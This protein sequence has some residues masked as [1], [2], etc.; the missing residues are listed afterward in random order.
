MQN[1]KQID[2]PF[3]AEEH[4]DEAKKIFGTDRVPQVGTVLDAEL[5][6]KMEMEIDLEY[7]HS[8]CCSRKYIV[9]KL[10]TK[11]D[12]L[13]LHK[14]FGILSLMSYIYRY[15]YVLPMTGTLGF[16]GGWFDYLTLAVHMIL[17]TSSMIFHVLPQRMIRRPLVIWEEYR[18]HAIFFSLR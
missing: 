6:A 17:S 16:D 8:Y 3:A 5:A 13:F 14:T 18:L 1:G 9:K 2:E 11:E 12:P 7:K 4:S 10:V 15:C